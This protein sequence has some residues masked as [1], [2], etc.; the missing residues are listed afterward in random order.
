MNS[1]TEL[2]LSDPSKHNGYFAYHRSKIKKKSAC[3]TVNVYI[4][5]IVG[6]YSDCFFLQL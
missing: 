2:H 6:T 5:T 3:Y 4:H 1:D